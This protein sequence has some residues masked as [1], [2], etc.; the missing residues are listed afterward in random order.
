MRAKKRII[1]GLTAILLPV[2][3]LFA[4]CASNQVSR[5]VIDKKTVMSDQYGS[6]ETHSLIFGHVYQ[7][8]VFYNLSFVGLDF[9]QINPAFPPMWITAG[10]AK[11][12]FFIPPLPAG[13]AVHMTSFIFGGGEGDILYKLGFQKKTSVSSAPEKSGLHYAG[14]YKKIV[15]RR[16]GIKVSEYGFELTD[17]CTEKDALKLI[18]PGFAGTA[19]EP[20]ITARIKELEYAD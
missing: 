10:Q 3:F 16:T 5:P 7:A 13:A 20:L 15:N 2:I 12:A 8:E 11:T 6:P 18:L 14:A 1:P 19:W 4:G 9:V 17:S